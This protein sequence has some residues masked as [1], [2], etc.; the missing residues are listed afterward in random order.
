MIGCAREEPMNA[1]VVTKYYAACFAARL[2]LS[3]LG[4]NIAGVSTYLHEI[5]RKNHEGASCQLQICTLRFKRAIIN[6]KN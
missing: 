4:V 5:L 2:F 1:N 6:I 3:A